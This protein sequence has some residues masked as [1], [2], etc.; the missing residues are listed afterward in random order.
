MSIV[1]SR[2]LE[3]QLPPPGRVRPKSV[4][5]R[6]VGRPVE[7]VKPSRAKSARPGGASS[8]N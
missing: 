6:M 5:A 2:M 7:L 3:P 1:K 4:G 8:E